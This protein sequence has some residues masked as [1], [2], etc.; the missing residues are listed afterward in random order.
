VT[1]GLELGKREGADLG[2]V[3]AGGSGPAEQGEPLHVVV[4]IEPLAAFGPVRGDH[5]VATLPGRS[6][7]ALRPVLDDHPHGVA[8]GWLMESITEG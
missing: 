6:T 7:S 1:R 3:P 4:G 5:P 8:W 2:D